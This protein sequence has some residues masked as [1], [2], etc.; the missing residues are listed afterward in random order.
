[1]TLFLVIALNWRQVYFVYSFVSIALYQLLYFMF[2]FRSVHENDSERALLQVVVPQCVGHVEQ[3]AVAVILLVTRVRIKRFTEKISH[4]GTVQKL[5]MFCYYM[6]FLAICFTLESVGL[7]AINVDIL[8]FI[9]WG[10]SLWWNLLRHSRRLS[11]LV[12]MSQLGGDAK[13]YNNTATFAQDLCIV[14]FSTGWS[15][16]PVPIILML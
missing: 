2:S 15:M 3:L 13:V 7:A 14:I 12:L 5:D 16:C 1:M 11:S 10:A 8:N 4:P 6:V 9:F